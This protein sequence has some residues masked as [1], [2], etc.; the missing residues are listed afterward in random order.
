MKRQLSNFL[1]VLFAFASLSAF[2]QQ[3]V[4]HN[5]PFNSGNQNM[6]GPSTSSFSMNQTW[7]LLDEGFDVDYTLDLIESLAGSD[8]GMEVKAK[9]AA[10]FKFKFSLQGFTT[11]QVLVNYPINVLLDMP[12]DNTYDPGDLVTIE[13]SYTLNPGAQIQTMYPNGGEASLDLYFGVSAKLSAKICAFGC[14]NIPLIPQVNLS[15]QHVNIFTVNQTGAEFLSYNGAAPYSSTGFTPINLGPQSANAHPPQVMAPA[16][17]S[18]YGLTGTLDVPYVSTTSSIAPG[19]GGKFLKACGQDKYVDMNLDVF[20][21]ISS[22]APAPYSEI[23]ENLSGS[24]DYPFNGNVYWNFLSASLDLKDYNKQCFDFKP[25]VFAKLVFPVAVEYTILNGASVV[26]TGN[27]SIVNVQVGN[28][29]RYKFPCYFEE[30]DIVPTYK[31][32]GTFTNKT[33]DSIPLDFNISALEFGVSID[34]IEVIPEIVIPEVCVNIPYPCPTWSNPTKWCKERVCTPEIVTPALVFDGFSESIGPLFDETFN[35]VGIKLPWFSQTWN[36]EGFSQYTRPAFTMRAEPITITNTFVDAACNGS[37]SGSINVTINTVNNANP[38]TYSWSNGATTQ[39]ITA[40]GGG[41][42]TL[43]AVDNNGCS[44]YTGATISE[45]PLLEGYFSK[46]DKSCNGAAGDGTI[47]VTVFGGTA[48]YSY[49]WSNG[50]TTQDLAGL[51]SGNYTLTVTDAKLCTK[52]IAVTITQP[53]T[54]GQNGMVTPVNCLN[55]GDGEIDIAPFG[56]T[57]PYTFSWSS[58]QISE[59]LSGLTSATYTHTLTDANGCTSVVPYLVSE[60]PTAIALS[61]APIDVSC[62][63]G[64]NGG[65]N[66]TTIGGTPGYS[67]TWVSVAGGVL[68]YISEDISSVPASTYTVI[69]TDMNGCMDTISQ[70]VSQPLA[71]LSSSPVLVDILCFGAATGSIDPFINGGTVPYSY[72]WS[73]SSNAA[74]QSG[75]LAG[76]YTLAVTDNNG[77]SANYSYT[78]S[79]PNA[80]L[81]LALTGTNVLCFGDATG[82][83]L[84]ST[85]GGTPS[86]TYSWSNGATTADITGVIA[87]N[88]SVLITDNNGCTISDNLT[89]TQPAAPLALNSV[90]THVD[91]FGANSGAIDLSISGGTSPYLKSWS[92]GAALVLSDT[93]EDLSAQFSDSYEVLITD[94]NGCTDTL[95]ST[96]DQPLAPLAITGVVVDVN[97]FGFNDGAIDVSVTGGTTNY[98]YSWSSG[99]GSEDISAVLAG[100]YTITVTDLNNCMESASFTIQQP[101]LPLNVTT[102]TTDV[103]CFGGTTGSVDAE[104]SGGTSPYLYTWSTGD[105]TV[106]IIDQTA[107]IYTLTIT[108]D[109]GCIAFTGTTILEPTQL[110]LSSLVT[111]ASCFEYAD[112]KIVVTLTGGVAPYYLNWGNENQI[113][114]EFNGDTLSNLSTNNYL[115]R[116]TDDNGCMTEQYIFVG[117]PQP[118]VSTNLVTDALC[119]GSA[120]GEIEVTIAGGTLPYASTWTDGASSEDRTN[121]ISGTYGY[122]V[123]DAQGCVIVDSV[124]VDEPKL[125]QIIQEVIEV[126]CIDQTDAQILISP[127][128]G[129]PPYFYQWSTGE[130]SANAEDL[131]PGIYELLV[132][133]AH[134]CVVPFTFEIAINP[135]ECLGVPNTFTPNGDNYNDTWVISNLDLYPNAEVKIFNKWG[136]QVFD[137]PVPYVEW[138]GTHRGN[139]LP[140]EVYYFIIVLNNA[141]Q[142]EYTGTITIIR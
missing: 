60:P 17:L 58:G 52:V 113:L 105:T 126:S 41:T 79:E 139:D 120:D 117:E 35:I 73:N 30:M 13:T 114:L 95:I 44:F 9:I 84:T 135:D 64:N 15:N 34:D 77:C 62:F 61:S 137:T 93:T 108:D 127:Y 24:E 103:L 51:N 87:G 112:G 31:I 136:N 119:F 28:D 80:P 72:V 102:F 8:F 96:I 99:Q 98:A 49:S 38:Y 46:T 50:A 53:T 7:T 130:A 134:A 68:P 19:S 97:C 110:V 76:T 66:V 109:Q 3:Q 10:D 140:A 32:T 4:N 91:C 2:A 101:N 36:L 6:W 16:T 67:F 104:V 39:D 142:N 56:G 90:I 138:D 88:Y 128:G 5:L 55:G 59:D 45:P 20:Q 121:L 123:L 54:L 47:D 14:T 25:K 115:V 63:G 48:P 43:L 83:I 78:L 75:I 107:G 132:S 57:L 85:A 18:D 23:F 27:S 124:F 133:D 33:Y 89:L 125:I 92:N 74:T 71:P 21:L 69:A 70:V 40:L 86:Y 116:V 37:N 131:P 94:F 42:Y 65:V 29:V 100:N 22:V 122:T 129:V 111:D 118:F 12:T 106:S 141:E 1:S 26:T 82:A 81:S 11:G